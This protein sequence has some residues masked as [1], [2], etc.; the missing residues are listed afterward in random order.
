M[1]SQASLDGKLVVLIGGSGFLGTHVAQALLARG[2][3]LRVASRHPERAFRLRPL[4]NL[5]Q[6]QFARVDV[7]R[8]ASVA[9]AMAGAD[10]AVYLVGAFKG[11]LQALQADG[12]GI[13]AQAAAAAGA[14]A[15]A[16]VSA[17]GADA[18]SDISYARSKAD[19]ERQVLGAFPGATILRPSTLFGEDD[20]F[21]NLFA[22]LI[23]ALPVL[24]VFG[25]QAKLQP[26]WVDDAAEAIAGALADPAQHGGKTYEIAGPEPITMGALNRMIAAGQQRSPLFIELPDGA[27]ALFAALPLTPMNRDQ[28]HLLKAG[29]TPSGKYPGLKAFGI[30]PKPVELFLD[31]WMVRFRKHGRF[32]VK[33][34]AAR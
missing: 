12:A 1:T 31:R 13:A 5:G 30:V 22:G 25:A 24:P 26:L 23:G 4:A 11:D 17:I 29:S 9:A 15:F 3:R 10:A 32:G 2:A 14:Q 7:T 19:G 6:I 8:P 34:S 28:W 33:I 16:Y 27:S 18:D 20:K 21:I